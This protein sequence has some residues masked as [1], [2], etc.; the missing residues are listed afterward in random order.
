M[1]GQV[2]ISKA[3]EA[4]MPAL[5]VLMDADSFAFFE[6]TIGFFIE[7]KARKNSPEWI[8]ERV[9]NNVR[10]L[11]HELRHKARDAI[12]ALPSRLKRKMAIDEEELDALCELETTDDSLCGSFRYDM[13]VSPPSISQEPLQVLKQETQDKEDEQEEEAVVVASSSSEDSQSVL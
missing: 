6:S 4:L 10:R 7:F 9:C 1:G 2:L 13:T 5:S 12:H 11:R 3:T 8:W